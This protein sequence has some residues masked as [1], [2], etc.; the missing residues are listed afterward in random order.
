MKLSIAWIF[1]HINFDWEKIDI[2][3]LVSKFN[4]TTAEI[5]SFQ[6]IHTDLNSIFAVKA[7]SIGNE[8]VIVDCPEIDEEIELPKRDD[9]K[10][11][12][13]FLIYKNHNNYYWAKS[14]ALGGYKDF[15]LPELLIKDENLKKNW[16]KN[17][18]VDDY[19]IEIDNKSI[20]HRPDLWGHRG[21]AREIAAILDLELLPIENFIEPTE[22]INFNNYSDPTNLNPFG[23]KIENA[24][25][26]KRFATTYIKNVKN[27]PS[28]LFI[29]TRLSRIDS[30]AIN[31]IV[32]S[33]NYV[34]FDI[35]QPLHSFDADKIKGNLISIRFATP[36]EKFTLLDDETVE[37][38]HDLVVADQQ[39][40]IALAG[41]MG[42]KNS[43]VD[44]FTKSILI[45]SAC[46]DAS[47]IRK[48]SIRLKKRTEA[49]ARFEKS[50]DPNQNIIAIER[51]IKVMDNILK[52]VDQS[53]EVNQIVSL[54]NIVKTK[55]IE[56]EHQFI[57]KK[58]GVKIDSEFVIKTL[59]KLEF[60]VEIEKKHD[61]KIY[62]IT[63]PS[64]RSS[65]DI[66]IAQDIVEEIGRFFQYENIPFVLPSKQMIPSD[67]SHV[68][69]ERKIKQLLAFSCRMNEVQNYPFFDESFLKQLEWSPEHTISIVSPVS[70]NWKRL[71]TS[72]IPHLLKNI[73]QNLSHNQIQLF[74]LNRIW[75]LKKN[76]PQEKKVLAGIFFNQKNKINFYEMKDKL[77]LLFDLLKMNIKWEKR[78]TSDFFVDFWYS[79]YQSA[80]LIYQDEKIGIAGIISQEFLNKITQ[81]DAFIF[82]INADILLSSISKVIKFKP[83]Q[84]Y[85]S[86]Y[87]DIS[88][89]INLDK[90]VEY[91]SN[92]IENADTRI[93]KVELLD[94]FEKPE[95]QDKRSLTFR[96]HFVDE[97]KTL[98]KQEIED[99]SEKVKSEVK[100]LGAEL[101]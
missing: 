53:L 68:M 20:T 47:T 81:G 76:V 13:V 38:N 26:C 60:S 39:G 62:I 78:T 71:V 59:E 49:S 83:L 22:V 3:N 101:R 63:V 65:K 10:L 99:V 4:K 44:K 11:G 57:E 35:G 91:I 18:E 42:G 95:W 51:F 43:E 12:Q 29:A 88:L 41:I 52:I 74:E 9:I 89:L 77:N 55:K 84:K 25:I 36:A 87:L 61:T 56:I 100:K 64:L 1:D 23:T 94:M 54:G 45:E 75:N 2:Q 69:K 80:D 72:L 16:K 6:K 98:T 40:P 92:L 96:Y 21:F 27:I 34:M 82:E 17:F 79:K 14:S 5:E 90:T 28:D 86:N 66:A 46:F 37:L 48:S 15:N 97:Q 70:E 24:N 31:S 93:Y 58:L 73:Q 7:K 32:D 50:L 8:T 85:Q 19:I 67:I 30:K 33:T